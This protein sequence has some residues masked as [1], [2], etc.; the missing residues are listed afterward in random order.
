M[1]YGQPQAAIE[2]TW[3]FT[4]K[5]LF[6]CN[7][8]WGG[9][10]CM[11]ISKKMGIREE[12]YSKKSSQNYFC[13]WKFLGSHY[14]RYFFVHWSFLIWRVWP[15]HAWICHCSLQWPHRSWGRFRFSQPLRY[16]SRLKVI[17]IVAYD[18]FRKHSRILQCVPSWWSLFKERPEWMFLMMATLGVSEIFAQ[19]IMPFLLPMKSKRDWGEQERDWPATTRTFVLTFLYWERRY[20]AECCR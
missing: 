2:V 1:T 4:Q 17:I 11:Q 6:W 18:T 19:S 5:V 7:R 10:D 14:V 9:W 3:N 12:G 8:C 15:I 16:H 13:S 20:L